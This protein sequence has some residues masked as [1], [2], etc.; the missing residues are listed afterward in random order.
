MTAAWTKIKVNI[1][2]VTGWI[3]NWIVSRRW[4]VCPGGRR[5]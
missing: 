2:I 1:E 5:A 3:R 4:V